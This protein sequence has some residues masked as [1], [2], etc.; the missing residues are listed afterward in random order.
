MMS[1]SCPILSDFV[2]QISSS[3]ACRAK[4]PRGHRLPGMAQ[5]LT[6]TTPPWW[7]RGAR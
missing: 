2:L 5:A 4:G 7:R 6:R 1:V 3:L